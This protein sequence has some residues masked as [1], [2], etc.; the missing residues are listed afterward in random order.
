MEPASSTLINTVLER[1]P[2]L[3]GLV[4]QALSG[5]RTNRLW[6]AGQ[7]VIKVYDP[8]AASPLFPNNPLAE[9]KALAQLG[10]QGF[11][12]RLI[13]SGDGWL[14]YAYVEGLNWQ[15]DPVPVARLLYRLHRLHAEGFRTCPSGSAAILAQA[16]A[17]AAGC[18]ASLPPAPPDP[19]IGPVTMP[20]LIHGDAVSGNMIAGPHGVTLI[21][22]Q[23]P[24]LG[25]PV[26]DI[27]TFLSPAMQSLYRG[28][29]LPPAESESFL[30]AYPDRMVTDR[31][32]RL[33]PL[34]RWRMAAHCLWKAERGAT[35]YLRAM[36]LELA[37]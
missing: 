2:A 14:A 24:A 17:I 25:D 28:T 1:L 7:T 8:A 19:A 5:G 31:Y 27:A 30:Q 32:R 33:A 29:A 35:D 6:R 37:A 13:C 22:W 36:E 34:F 18:R 16:R 4:W 10:P 9:A 26:E 21:D 12:P 20:R 3:R 23:C 15:S 11:A